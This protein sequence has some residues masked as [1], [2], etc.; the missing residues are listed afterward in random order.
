MVFKPDMKADIR[1]ISAIGDLKWRSWDGVVADLW[2]A[3]AETGAEG[4]YLSRHHRLF[5]VLDKTSREINARLRPEGPDV[6]LRA[7]QHASF[8]PAGVP[9]WLQV[10]AATQLRHLDVHFDLAALESRFERPLPPSRL[11]GAR[12]VFDDRRMLA[13]ARLLA[14][15]CAGQGGHGLFGDG[16]ALAMLG[17]LLREDEE[18]VASRR[19][20]LPAWQLHKVTAFIED[21]CV[22]PIRLQQLAGITGLSQSYFSRAFKEATGVPPHRWHMQARVR[23][24]QKLLCD[25]RIPLNEI[26]VTTGFADQAHFTRVFRDVVGLPPAAWRRSM[27]L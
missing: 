23:R 2:H 10:P 9:L 4:V 27:V 11:A 14:E 8:I 19:P 6:A 22:E 26:A 24:A 25:A 13:L 20:S 17:E 18:A 3:R 15:E 1:G 12:L 5:V 16:V 7:A 21:H